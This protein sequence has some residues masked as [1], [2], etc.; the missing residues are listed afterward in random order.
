LYELSSVFL[1][2]AA[3]VSEHDSSGAPFDILLLA[4]LNNAC[5][6]SAILGFDT[7]VTHY[8]AQIGQVLDQCHHALAPGEKASMQWT[9]HK[10]FFA[11][12]VWQVSW[13]YEL[14]AAAA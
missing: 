5:H 14:L 3:G 1:A 9:E 8:A 12:T 10:K 4:A 13:R 11:T 6:I 7:A 2:E